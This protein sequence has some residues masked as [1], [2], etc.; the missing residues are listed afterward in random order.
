MPAKPDIANR[1]AARAVL[2]NQMTDAQ[3]RRIAAATDQPPADSVD[4][5][6][7]PDMAK[8]AWAFSPS[9]QPE[10]DFWALHDQTLQAAMAQLPPD[11]PPEQVQAAHN[12]A[13]TTAL[14]QV[15]PYRSELVG[16]GTRM[17]DAQID[18]AARIKRLVEG[19]QA[20][21]QA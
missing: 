9:P 21:G 1:F 3:A 14:K 6:K 4:V 18:R 19:D 11:A 5:M 12:M 8:R 13:E 16:I 7:Q 15:Y 17:L 10:Q 20:G 2:F